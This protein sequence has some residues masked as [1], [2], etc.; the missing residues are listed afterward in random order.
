M[1]SIRNQKGI[2]LF[3]AL[4]MSLVI[5]AMVTGVLYFV[6]QS[7]KMSGAGKRYT[8]ADEAAAGSIDIIKDSIN[9]TIWGG[10]ISGLIDDSGSE[11]FADAVL[12]ESDPC[13]VE[14]N[15]PGEVG[16][17]NAAVTLER[18]FSRALPGGRL[19][20]SRSAGGAP[21]TA[22]FY[23]ITTR[24]KGPGNSTAENSALYRWAG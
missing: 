6:T 1:K 16:D 21:S 13:A 19:E 5:M 2:A 9:L 24:I 7:T 11:C 4:L 8:T 14:I 22:I 12:L 23:R 17:F 18:L 20:F 15:L 3:T 10:S